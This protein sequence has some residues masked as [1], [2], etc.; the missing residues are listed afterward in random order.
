MNEIAHRFALLLGMGT[1]MVIAVI[2]WI[3]GV[4]PLQQSF[5][6][7][8]CGLAVYLLVRLAL[9]V[10]GEMVLSRLVATREAEE[11]KLKLESKTQVEE[12]ETPA[13]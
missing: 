5:R 7:V 1:A 12:E 13:A 3:R 2:T 4:T 6:A 8:V 10:G 9:R 11:Q